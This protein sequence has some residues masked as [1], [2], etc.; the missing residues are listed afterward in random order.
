MAGVKAQIN[1][2]LSQQFADLETAIEII[3]AAAKVDE[4]ETG[5]NP[6]ADVLPSDVIQLIRQKMDVGGIT[7]SVIYFLARNS[8]HEL[9]RLRDQKRQQMSAI[10]RRPR[11]PRIDEDLKERV[12]AMGWRLKGAHSSHEIVG[13]ISQQISDAPSKKTIRK[14]LREAG[15]IEEMKKKRI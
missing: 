8:M 3:K 2:E 14:Y 11:Q 12:V 15:V 5:G 6:F 1:A 7:E 4:P 9:Q 13:T 10:A